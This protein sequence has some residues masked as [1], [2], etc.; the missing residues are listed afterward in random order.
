MKP[1]ASSS[2]PVAL[3]STSRSSNINE[4]ELER[5][6]SLCQRLGLEAAAERG[7]QPAEVLLQDEVRA[8]QLL[9][10]EADL[11]L[12]QL[13]ALVLRFKGEPFSRCF[14][15]VTGWSGVC[16]L[17]AL[18][19]ECGMSRRQAAQAIVKFPGL[20]TTYT[21]EP[22]TLAR[23][24]R[25]HLSTD[26]A[27]KQEL[28]GE[29]SL[30]AT[31]VR[32]PRLLALDRD[33][34]KVKIHELLRLVVNPHLPVPGDIVAG[35]GPISWDR[36]FCGLLQPALRK[37]PQA[38]VGRGV[39]NLRQ[40]VAWLAHQLDLQQRAT[41]AAARLLVIAAGLDIRALESRV[42]ALQLEA[43]M[44]LGR[45]VHQQLEAATA[46]LGYMCLDQAS[47]LRD[48]LLTCPEVLLVPA[49]AV[50]ASAEA[51]RGRCQGDQELAWSALQ[52]LLRWAELGA[53]VD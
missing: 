41:P 35:T 10:E 5:L 26:W 38:L 34:L 28:E 9:L 48:Y 39:R 7:H 15:H 1:T 29:G 20:L 8:M 2:G 24:L 42:K 32:E 4:A 40:R 44:W 36:H 47:A 13:E 51:L 3:L 6:A 17:P 30:A 11:T 46:L 45:A 16:I 25:W 52:R 31:L 50:S 23:R 49:K 37:H 53:T 19:S 27:T 18:R 43:G 21:S 14:Q 12:A 22:A 33:A